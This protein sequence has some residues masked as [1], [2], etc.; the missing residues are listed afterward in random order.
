MKSTKLIAAV[1]LFAGIPATHA[2]VLIDSSGITATATGSHSAPFPASNTLD[3]LTLEGFTNLGTAGPPVR[4]GGH[5]NNHWI[6][7]DGMLT[8]AITFD[9]GGTYELTRM[10]VLNTSNTN[11]NDRETDTFTIETSTDGG[12]SYSAPSSA[13]T[14]Q[15]YTLG[16][17]NVPFNA[18]GVTHVRLNVTNDP[19]AGM[20]TGTTDSAVGLNEVQF[21][22]IPEPSSAIL[23]GLGS[24][25][26][27][28]RKRRA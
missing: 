11:W 4:P 3:G 16:F 23:L 22:T 21:Y 5:Q 19:G 8:S 14:L 9:L 18:S 26:F 12:G 20:N 27:L 17:Q 25:F 13:I 2:V 28:R 1:T 15:D 7:P 10:E 6:T 24:A